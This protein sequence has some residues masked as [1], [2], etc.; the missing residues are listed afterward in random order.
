MDILQK[1]LSATKVR[2]IADAISAITETH[3]INWRPVDDNENNLATINLG[4]DPAAGVVE[5]ITNAFDAVL[6]FEWLS[7]GQPTSLMSPRAAVEQWFN[8]R[9]GRLSSVEDLRSPDIV[10]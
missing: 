5:R 6:E 4:S 7:R 2:D 1:L 3:R 10:A 8:V 9:S